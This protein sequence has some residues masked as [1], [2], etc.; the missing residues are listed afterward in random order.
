MG[1]SPGK[2]IT[3]YHFQLQKREGSQA[4]PRVDDL[5]L[6]G[7]SNGLMLWLFP[8]V[9]EAWWAPVLQ[10]WELHVDHAW[11]GSEKRWKFIKMD[12]PET[13]KCIHVF[14][15]YEI[16]EGQSRWDPHYRSQCS[17]VLLPLDGNA[18][19]LFVN[20]NGQRTGPEEDGEC[21]GSVAPHVLFTELLPFAISGRPGYRGDACGFNLQVFSFSGPDISWTNVQRRICEPG[22]MANA[23][24][25]ASPCMRRCFSMYILDM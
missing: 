12:D 15:V 23:T 13:V 16:T 4:G 11:P 24:A 18:T 3:F 14:C 5:W 19:L 10:V 22:L 6:L 25:T 21:W 2:D 1:H 17:P 8:Q 7:W 20:A 9:S